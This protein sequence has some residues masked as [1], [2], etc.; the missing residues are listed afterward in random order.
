[1]CPQS[2][3][4]KKIQLLKSL[5]IASA[6]FRNV[7]SL[8]QNKRPG[9]TQNNNLIQLHVVIHFIHNLLKFSTL[10]IF[11][12]LTGEHETFETTFIGDHCIV[13]GLNITI[14]VAYLGH[15]VRE[16]SFLIIVF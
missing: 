9:G 2:M 15:R 11:F 8:C 14:R 6:S 3:V 16:H 12:L 4:W 10:L 13:F 7:P 1:M 5:Y